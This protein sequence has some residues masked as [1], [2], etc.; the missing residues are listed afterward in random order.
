MPKKAL[1]SLTESMFYVLM[2]FSAGECCGAE[3][4]QFV[5]RRTG[6]ALRLGPATLYTLLGKFEEVGYITETAVD[7]RRRTYA[8]TAAG[9]AAYAAELARLRRCVADAEAAAALP[10]AAKPLL[11]GGAGRGEAALA[12]VPLP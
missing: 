9:R 1:E 7:G 8:I 10:Y 4:V 3:V 5:A 6:G 12:P 2:A 11:E